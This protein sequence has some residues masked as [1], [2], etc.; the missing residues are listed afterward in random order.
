MN[1]FKCKLSHHSTSSIVLYQPLSPNFTQFVL[2]CKS[3]CHGKSLVDE[4]LCK[5]YLFFLEFHPDS[6]KINSGELSCMIDK[7]LERMK[8]ERSIID[9]VR[10]SEP[11]KARNYCVCCLNSCGRAFCVKFVTEARQPFILPQV[12]RDCSN[13]D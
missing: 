5:F 12:L 10:M 6:V 8:R 3:S 11:K 9:M 13:S 1:C 4:Y 2:L 7:G